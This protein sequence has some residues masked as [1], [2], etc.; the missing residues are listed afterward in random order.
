MHKETKEKVGKGEIEEV[1][2][3]PDLTKLTKIE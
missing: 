3:I 2:A 1:M